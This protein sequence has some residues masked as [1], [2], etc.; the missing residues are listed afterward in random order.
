M[1]PTKPIILVLILLALLLNSCGSANF[2]TNRSIQKRK[3]NKGWFIKKPSRISASNSRESSDETKVDQ[4]DHETKKELALKAEP[5]ESLRP[6]TL[7]AENNSIGAVDIADFEAVIA[8]TS[9]RSDFS[10]GEN[11]LEFQEFVSIV[12]ESAPVQKI[13]AVS[14]SEGMS[15]SKKS[16]ILFIVFALLAILCLL[17]LS[18]DSIGWG[19]AL[20]LGGALLLFAILTIA[21]GIRALVYRGK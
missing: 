16:F 10:E 13:K 3:Y 2:S 18:L 4:L 21:H 1:T 17:I 14:N 8:E 12:E 6:Q 9:D 7:E 20:I 5:R 19:L 15:K 11:V